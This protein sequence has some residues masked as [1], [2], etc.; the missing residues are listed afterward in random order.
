MTDQVTPE[1]VRYWLSAT[2]ECPY[3]LEEVSRAFLIQTQRVIQLRHSINAAINNYAASQETLIDDL[4]RMSLEDP[5]RPEAERYIDYI[6]AFLMMLV[7]V[8]QSTSSSEAWVEEYLKGF[9]QS[10]K[11]HRELVELQTQKIHETLLKEQSE[12]IKKTDYAFGTLRELRDYN[13]Q[14]GTLD[15]Y[16][17]RVQEAAMMALREIE[18]VRIQ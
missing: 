4:S 2:G 12:L 7:N 15:A 6:R 13:P 1:K 9:E 17:K 11:A 3:T 8:L 16:K 10:L 5:Q 14:T 18:G